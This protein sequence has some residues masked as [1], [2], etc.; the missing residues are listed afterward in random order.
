MF[1]KATPDDC[2]KVYELICDMENTVLPYDDFAE[3][4][5]KQLNDEK[6]YCLL[7]DMDEKVIGIL[8]LRFEDQLHHADRIAEILELAVDKDYRNNG[9]GKSLLSQ[10][11]RIAKQNGCVQI[12]VDCNQIRHDTHRFYSREG[13]QNSHYKFTKV[14]KNDGVDV[15]PE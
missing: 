7:Y 14:L 5:R 13:M 15:Q 10:A 1:R 9:I 11:C 12:E 3:I 8:N 4:L 2:E 6:Y